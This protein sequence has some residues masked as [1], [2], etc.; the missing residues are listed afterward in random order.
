MNLRP[1]FKIFT[2]YSRQAKEYFR[3]LLN[4]QLSLG[5]EHNLLIGDLS[6]ARQSCFGRRDEICK[7]MMPKIINTEASS[8]FQVQSLNKWLAEWRTGWLNGECHK[9][10]IINITSVTVI[11][12]FIFFCAEISLGRSLLAA[13]RSFIEQL[14]D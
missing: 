4:G 6:R 8:C 9:C 2:N 12:F 3:D 10:K 13:Y 11:F 1:T 7:E 5:R 14:D